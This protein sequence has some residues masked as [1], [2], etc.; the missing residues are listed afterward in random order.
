MIERLYRRRRRAGRREAALRED[1]RSGSQ[2]EQ[3]R[4]CKQTDER[5]MC[6]AELLSMEFMRRGQEIQ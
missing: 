3:E 6:L 2:A 4:H 1:C 5:T